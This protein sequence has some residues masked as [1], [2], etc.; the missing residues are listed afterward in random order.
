MALECEMKIKISDIRKIQNR[1]ER[2]GAYSE[3][4]SLEKNWILDTSGGKNRGNGIV[5]RIRNNGG[6]GGVLTVK[7][8]AKGG[9][10]KTREEL[11]TRVECTETLLTQFKDIGY[12]VVWA[13]EKY[14]QTWHWRDCKIMLDECPEI[15]CFI[16]I[17]GTPDTIR[18]TAAQLGLDP[19]MHISGGY[20]KLWRKHLNRL[21]QKKRHMLFP[22]GFSCQLVQC[23]RL[24]ETRTT[25]IGS[26]RARPYPAARS[27][28]A[29]G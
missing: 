1:L 13:Y 2:I 8:P 3:G 16:E 25:G 27:L 12:A 29:A 23:G 9:P 17:E 26:N 28:S 11:E 7:R 4:C 10:F 15:G 22:R 5:L 6:T 18:K 24:G 19:A 20:R 21:G 14:R